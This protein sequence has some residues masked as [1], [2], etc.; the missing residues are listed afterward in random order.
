MVLCYRLNNKR[1]VKMFSTTV[2]FNF[3]YSC[4]FAS[5]A[6][7][8]LILEIYFWMQDTDVKSYFY[9]VEFPILLR[10]LFFS[11]HCCIINLIFFLL[12]RQ[13]IHAVQNQNLP[14]WVCVVAVFCFFVYCKCNLSNVSGNVSYLV[15]VNTSSLT[16]TKPLT[17]SCTHHCVTFEMNLRRFRVTYF[18]GTHTR[19]VAEVT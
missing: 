5:W 17:N 1:A 10:N 12:W 2:R 7:L 6:V 16:L 13:L 18:R 15:H 9:T 11:F 14:Q 3:N 4:H 19:R 8:L